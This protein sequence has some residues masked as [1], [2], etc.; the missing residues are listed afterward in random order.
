MDLRKA[1]DFQLLCCFQDRSNDFRA[2]YRL[3]QKLQVL[4][5]PLPPSHLC[6]DNSV[7]GFSGVSEDVD[8]NTHVPAPTR[9]QM[10]INL[11]MGTQVLGAQRPG[12]TTFPVI[13]LRGCSED[14]LKW[15]VYHVWYTANTK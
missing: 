7:T 14:F 3:D 13:C 9:E 12:C 1:V 6:A 2:P 4:P 10:P 5:H 11:P 15:L 8:V